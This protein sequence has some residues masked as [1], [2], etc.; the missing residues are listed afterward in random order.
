MAI[1]TADNGHNHTAHYPRPRL[2]VFF[3][4]SSDRAYPRL[5]RANEQY[6]RLINEV[7]RP[8]LP[9][10]QRPLLVEEQPAVLLVELERQSTSLLPEPRHL[11]P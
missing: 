10:P 9:L 8:L 11:E 5:R 1:I 4:L 7:E 2:L 3:S 6:S